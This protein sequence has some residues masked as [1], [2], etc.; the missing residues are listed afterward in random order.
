VSLPSEIIQLF[1]TGSVPVVVAGTVLGVFELG[2]RFASQR[3]KDAL[4][5]WL[6]SFD[7]QK[8][9]ALPDGTQELFERIFGDR[10]LSLRCF[11]RSVAFSLGSVVFIGI[12]CLFIAPQ[13]LF[14]DAAIGEIW[15]ASALWL[16]FSILIDYISLF[17]TRVILRI[18][19]LIKFKTVVAPLAIL[20][21]DYLVYVIINTIG[22]VSLSMFLNMWF[23]PS[24]IQMLFEHG[25][26]GFVTIMI[27][28]VPANF[29]VFPTPSDPAFYFI[30]FWAGF[31]PSLWMWLYVAALF[32]TVPSSVA[33]NSSIGFDGFLTLRKP[34]SD[35]SAQ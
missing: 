24:R 12:L 35:Q 7:V 34:H 27:K 23:F 4:S 6:L 8:A 22:A 13:R 20:I 3:A 11:S 17:K 31:A 30:L 16:P 21:I 10:H 32:V 25:V 29:S 1:G 14:A 18:L 9:R 2:E 5:R 33:K 15:L 19:A 26:V 28:E